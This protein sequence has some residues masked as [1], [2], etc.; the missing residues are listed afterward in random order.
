MNRRFSAPGKPLL[1]LLALAL[2][3]AAC[4]EPRPV[5]VPVGT[6]Q[7]TGLYW[8]PRQELAPAVALLPMLGGAKEDWQPLAARLH[9]QGYGVLAVDLREE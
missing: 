1:I 9:R 3:V 6:G 2:F 7:L 5:L 4:D 8:E